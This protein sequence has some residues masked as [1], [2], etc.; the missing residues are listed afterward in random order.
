[1]QSM[2]PISWEFMLLRLIT[3]RFEY[4]FK[5]VLYSYESSTTTNVIVFTAC[6]PKYGCCLHKMVRKKRDITYPERIHDSVVI[7]LV[8]TDDGSFNHNV[9]AA[10]NPL[11]LTDT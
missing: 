10:V 4:K 5:Q 9:S 2:S 11:I 7:D 8:P 1:M 3:F 6:L